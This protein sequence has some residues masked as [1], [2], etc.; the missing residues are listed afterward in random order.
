MKINESLEIHGPGFDGTFT[1]V[2]TGR[3]GMCAYYTMPREEANRVLEILRRGTS[4]WWLE[5]AASIRSYDLKLADGP[6]LDVPVETYDTDR[7]PGDEN[8]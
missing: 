2:I 3:L 4:D 5:Q 1:W 7:D 6:L 8:A